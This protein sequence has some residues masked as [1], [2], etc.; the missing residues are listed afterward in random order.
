MAVGSLF[1]TGTLDVNRVVALGGPP[2]QR[3]RLLETRVG[4]S[5]DELLAGELDNVETRQI[6]GSVLSGRA[7]TGDVEGYLGRYHQQIS[8]L[9][10]GREREFFGWLGPGLNKFSTI[11]T[12]VSRLLP[13]RPIR[14]TTTSHGSRRAIVPIGMFEKVLPF[15]LLPTPLLRIVADA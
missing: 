8:V 13:G 10:E 1:E 2:V 7:A 14:F 6:S 4:A 15:D 11:S 5:I 12:F 3:P 9:E